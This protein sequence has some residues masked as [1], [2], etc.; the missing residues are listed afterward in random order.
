MIYPC[1]YPKKKVQKN[2]SLISNLD[3]RTQKKY[4]GDHLIKQR[5][6]YIH[7]CRR[8]PHSFSSTSV[9]TTCRTA[10]AI[11]TKNWEKGER[12]KQSIE[13]SSKIPHGN[14][15]RQGVEEDLR[16]YH[17]VDEIFPASIRIKHCLFNLFVRFK[18]KASQSD[19][20][21]LPQ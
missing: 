13:Y 12:R 7:M 10:Y 21:H 4:I 14:V 5:I 3:T 18:K 11:P 2:L 17:V 8:V 9:G 6:F 1:Y 15:H 19:I 20:Q 16:A